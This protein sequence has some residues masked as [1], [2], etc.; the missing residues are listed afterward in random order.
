MSD[1]YYNLF[2]K[3]IEC[4]FC[5]RLEKVVDRI[6]LNN[7]LNPIAKHKLLF[8]DN[9]TLNFDKINKDKTIPVLRIDGVQF[10]GSSKYG[11]MVVEE[12]S[13]IRGLL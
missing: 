2:I 13:K 11:N 5:K 7:F 10:I 8:K 12:F 1:K 9:I 4:P 6:N 3:S